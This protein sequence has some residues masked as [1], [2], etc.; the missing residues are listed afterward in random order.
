MY[1]KAKKPT[2]YFIGVTTSK[3]SIMKVFPY[4]AESLG[5]GTCEI[6]GIDF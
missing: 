3:S 6:K 1:K 2:M 5:L 4:W